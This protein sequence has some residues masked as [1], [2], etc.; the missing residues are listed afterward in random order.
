MKLKPQIK[1]YMETEEFNRILRSMGK[2]K[3]KRYNELEKENKQLKE[4]IV[5]ARQYYRLSQEV[6]DV[7]RH[8]MPDGD[9][10]INRKDFLNS[11]G[12]FKYRPY[13]EGE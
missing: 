5:F 8:L 13:E 1:D 11:L 7:F 4:A 12:G 3:N 9:D 6:Y 2:K 10:K